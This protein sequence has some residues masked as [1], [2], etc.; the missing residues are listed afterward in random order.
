MPGS[1]SIQLTSQSFISRDN[2]CRHP[3]IRTLDERF[4]ARCKLGV[5]VSAGAATIDGRQIIVPTASRN[6]A[7]T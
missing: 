2:Y 7:I 3:S 6:A 1:S 4:L 5:L